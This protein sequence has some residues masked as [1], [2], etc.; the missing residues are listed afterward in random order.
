M[1]T[2]Q[3]CTVAFTDGSR[4]KGERVAGGWCDS[5]GGEGG[6]LVGLVATVWD[7]EITGMQLALQSLPMAPM[8]VLSDLR[9]AI[10]SVRNAA[11]CGHVRSADLG[12]VVDLAGSWTSV[13]VELC[14][15]WVKAHV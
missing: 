8:L 15:E 13:R 12:V 5:R 9:A 14:F 2:S 4:D 3:G 1:S 10:A 11:A 6:E 7:G